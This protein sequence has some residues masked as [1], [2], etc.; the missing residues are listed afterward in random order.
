MNRRELVAA[1]AAHTDQDPKAVD[2]T[3]RGLVDVVSAT[4]KKGDP[5]VMSGFTKWA[6]VKRAARTARN[7]QTGEPVKVKASQKVRITPLKALK[8]VAAGT[9]P[10]PK[11][12]KATAKKAATTTTRRARATPTTAE[13]EAPVKRTRATKASAAVPARRSTRATSATAAAAPEA[14]PA[15]KAATR[16]AT[17]RKAAAGETA[18]RKATTRKA[19]TRKA[20]GSAASTPA[21][22]APAKRTARS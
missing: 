10:A 11:L 4:I 1:V 15:R 5:V 9:A 20:A 8:D 12:T 2:Q 17:T 14:A 13:G 19:T 6:K 7:P 16:K 3:L 22:R 21:K 18:P